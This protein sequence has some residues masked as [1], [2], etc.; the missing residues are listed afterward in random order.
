MLGPKTRSHLARDIFLGLVIVPGRDD[1]LR[2]SAT[3]NAAMEIRLNGRRIATRRSGRF[4]PDSLL[5]DLPLTK[6]RNV[7]LIRL[8]RSAPYR[9]WKGR[10]RFLDHAFRPLSQQAALYIP[11]L[12]GP[13]IEPSTYLRMSVS[14][15][16]PDAAL[17][18]RLSLRAP[19]GLMLPSQA[20]HLD[21]RLG[22]GQRIHQDIDPIVL[23]HQ[24]LSIQLPERFFGRVLVLSPIRKVLRI[25]D[26][27]RVW[28]QWRRAGADLDRA[29]KT[30]PADTRDSLQ[31]H[32]DRLQHLLEA[33]DRDSAYLSRLARIIAK[34][35]AMAAAGTDPFARMHG[36]VVMA[37]RSSIDG[38]LQPYSLWIPRGARRR[39]MPLYVM[40]HGLE[41]SHRKGLN[42]MLGVWMPRED[43]TPWSRFTRRLPPPRVSPRALVL[44]PQAFG[45]S[46]YRHEGEVAVFEAIEAVRRRFRIDPR[47]IVLVGH[48]MGGTGVLALGLKHPDLFAGMVSLSG[49]PSRWIYPSIRRGPLRPWELAAARTW[50]PLLWVSNGRHLPLIAVHGTRDHA[51]RAQALVRAYQK[52]GGRARLSLFVEGH[53]VWR[54]Y[55]ADGRVY[56]QTGSWRKRPQRSWRLRTTRL[57]WNRSGPLSILGMSRFDRWAEISLKKTGRGIVVETKNVT[58]LAI[59]PTKLGRTEAPSVL[60]DGQTVPGKA[61][62]TSSSWIFARTAQGSWKPAQPPRTGKRPGLSGP[63]DDIYYGPVLVV[64]GTKDPN[65]EG[66]MDLLSRHF[67]RHHISSVRYPIIDDRHLTDRQA[68][69]ANLVL[70][71]GPALNSVTARLSRRLPI[72][73]DSRGI[74]LGNRVVSAPN[75]AVLFVAP[76]PEH[77]DRY[78]LVLEGNSRPAMARVLALPTYL[79]DWV[80]FDESIQQSGLPRILGPERKYL[81]A[82]WFDAGWR[83]P[84]GSSALVV[85]GQASSGSARAV[86]SR[87][88]SAAPRPMRRR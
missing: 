61:L 18:S 2:L 51:D 14:Q 39:K 56:L 72:Q 86:P 10:F 85:T 57:R 46:F 87:P 1:L 48:S 55:L 79:P 4:A 83:L 33:G 12:R 73:R 34:W 28:S 66:L 69:S 8:R 64:R 37:V 13:H 77:P 42:Q 68:A 75:A 5:V 32:L 60:I 16:F 74:H 82:V 63:I 6:G 44:A 49:Y 54:E 35:C 25:P 80:L 26:R 41:C 52:A 19:G 53:S 11:D 45:D 9:L 36:R 20:W 15:R 17:Q 50:S 76:N 23:A 71:G 59:D 43:P 24:G 70:L 65:A 40:L 38:S 29:P 21:V 22:S 31:F 81:A 67:A 62:G 58:S 30:I 78:L 27:R 3:S 47:R 84:A 7:L 88:K